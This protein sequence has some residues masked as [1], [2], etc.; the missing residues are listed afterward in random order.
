ML[1]QANSDLSLLDHVL[2]QQS[3]LDLDKEFSMYPDISAGG[4]FAHKIM[5]EGRELLDHILENTSFVRCETF[6][7][8]E[9]TQD[10]PSIVESE[11]VTFIS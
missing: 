5:M 7:E 3:Y 9:H 1:T 4:S 11:L 10:E 8:I 6:Q 2:V